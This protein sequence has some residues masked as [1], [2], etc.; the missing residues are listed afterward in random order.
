LEVVSFARDCEAD[1][2]HGILG[3]AEEAHDFAVACVKAF[4]GHECTPSLWLLA[5]EL[6]DE[7]LV[8]RFIVDLYIYVC[9]YI[10]I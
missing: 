10:Y 8:G 5:D 3:E 1:R 9:I 2:L 7:M 4:L 6:I